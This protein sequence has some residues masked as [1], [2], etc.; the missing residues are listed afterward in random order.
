MLSYDSQLRNQNPNIGKLT[1]VNITNNE[2][3]LAVYKMLYLNPNG[4]FH[5]VIASPSRINVQK[6]EVN[7]VSIP[8]IPSEIDGMPMLSNFG[9]DPIYI[10]VDNSIRQG[11]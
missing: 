3:G 11:N 6:E 1:G 8:K 5:S 4:S 2:Q 7:P 10:K 9:L